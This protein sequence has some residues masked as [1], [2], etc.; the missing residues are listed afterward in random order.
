MPLKKTKAK[1]TSRRLECSKP[2]FIPEPRNKLGAGGMGGGRGWG[3][4]GGGWGV[5]GKAVGGEEEGKT[6]VQ[7]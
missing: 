7:M 4:G 3:M 2:S 5:S 1:F 6:T